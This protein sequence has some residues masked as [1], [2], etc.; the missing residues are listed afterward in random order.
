MGASLT[1]INNQGLT[2]YDQSTPKLRGMMKATQEIRMMKD[3]IFKS[4]SHDKRIQSLASNVNDRNNENDQKR[5]NTDRLDDTSSSDEQVRQELIS[6]HKD[7]QKLLQVMNQH[8]SS[9]ESS[10]PDL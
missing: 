4:Y 7:T 2:P 8:I 5:E 6:I 9:E 10:S 1:L 3:E